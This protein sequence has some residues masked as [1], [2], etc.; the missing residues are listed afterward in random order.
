VSRRDQP[1]PPNWP[2][3]LFVELDA[4]K[5]Y[6]TLDGYDHFFSDTLRAHIRCFQMRVD[7]SKPLLERAE[8]RFRNHEINGESLAHYFRHRMIAYEH[9]VLQEALG[10][11]LDRTWTG[12]GQDLDRTWT[13]PGQNFVRPETSPSAAVALTRNRPA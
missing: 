4:E 5:A 10:Q 2:D 13:E 7:E 11:D 12:L 9:A 6:R 8:S 1:H 3:T